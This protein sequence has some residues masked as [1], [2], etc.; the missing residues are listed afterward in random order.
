AVCLSAGRTCAAVRPLSRA[1]GAGQRPGVRL[2]ITGR[3]E[4]LLFMML[5]R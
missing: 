1:P 4:R 5:A 3:R 2:R